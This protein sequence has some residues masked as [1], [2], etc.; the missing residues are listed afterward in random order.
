MVNKVRH[1][2][3]VEIMM[4]N[5]LIIAGKPSR[6]FEWYIRPIPYKPLAFFKLGIFFI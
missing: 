2:A 5:K 4:L 1:S 3:R 6:M